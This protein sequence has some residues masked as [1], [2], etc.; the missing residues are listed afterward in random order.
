MATG[1]G[2]RAALPVADCHSA[3]GASLIARPSRMSA[4]VAGRMPK[5][6]APGRPANQQR[7][8][9]VWKADPVLYISFSVFAD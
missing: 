9:F 8:R 4:M 7:R 6:L 5:S 2:G 1:A 3:G